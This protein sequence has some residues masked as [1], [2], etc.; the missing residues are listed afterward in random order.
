LKRLWIL[1][2]LT[3]L[4]TSCASKTKTVYQVDGMPIPDNVIK[5]RVFPIKST[6]TYNLTVFYDVKEGDETYET[7]EFL[8]LTYEHIHKIK[9]PKR[10]ELNVNVFNPLKEKYKIIKYISIEGAYKGGD[11]EEEEGEVV[12]EGELSRNNFIIDLPLVVAK[13]VSFYYDACDKNGTLAFRS[14]KAQYVIED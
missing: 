10:I 3:L 8:P 6:L 1:I 5:A 11:E 4:L 12:Y 13:Y 9:N 14:F 7:Y 2:I